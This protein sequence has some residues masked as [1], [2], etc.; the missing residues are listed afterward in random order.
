LTVQV[1]R[2]AGRLIYQPFGLRSSVPG[3]ATKTFLHLAA[4]ISYCS[5]Y[6]IFVRGSLLRLAFGGQFVTM[7]EGSNFDA[8]HGKSGNGSAGV[9]F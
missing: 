4:D 3:N 5:C 1:L 7:W 8:S 2:S 9:Q 6:A